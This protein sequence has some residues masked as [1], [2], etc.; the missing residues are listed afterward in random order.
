[1]REI[2][3]IA[4]TA[5]HHD[6]DYDFMGKLVNDIIKNSKTDILK[7]HITLDFDEY[8]HPLRTA[9]STFKGKL[10]TTNQW[11][12]LINNIKNN[13]KELMLLYNDKTAIEFGSAYEPEYVEIHSVC[14]NDIHL[15]DALRNNISNDTSVILGVGGSSLD[16][17]EYAIDRLDHDRIILMFGFQNYP[18]HYENINFRKMQRI[19]RLFPEL[20]YGYA[21]HSAWNEPENI[22]ITLMGAALGM[23][24]IEKHVTNAYG[25]E[26]VDWN[27]AISIDMFNEI[28]DKIEILGKCRGDGL[29]KLNDAEKK[30]SIYGP[31]KKT[32]VLKEDVQEGDI[33][34]LDKIQFQRTKEITDLSQLDIINRIGN[35]INEDL[36]AGSVL[37]R[38]HFKID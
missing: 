7:M 6:G 13:S 5:W 34:T 15:L 37:F 3:L 28:A 31:M 30:Y 27:S 2:K 33:L 16:E 32:A 18:T 22:L 38:T 10:F 1:M 4:E 20:N 29:M 8:S 11:K 19:M 12:D 21:D 25:K 23:D 36:K 26:R 17:I 14:L 24:Y 35:K 9:K